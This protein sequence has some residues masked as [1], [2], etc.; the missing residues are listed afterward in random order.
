MQE[1]DLSFKKKIQKEL[2]CTILKLGLLIFS[3]ANK[4]FRPQTAR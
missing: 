2:C 1:Q 4:V 3:L